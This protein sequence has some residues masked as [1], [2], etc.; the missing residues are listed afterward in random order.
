MPESPPGTVLGGLSFFKVRTME[1][2]LY[3]GKIFSVVKR[4]IPGT[5]PHDV[6]LHAPVVTII[7]FQ[8]NEQE[9]TPDVLLIETVRPIISPNPVLEVPAGFIE[10]GESVIEAAR[11]ELE[12]ETG[13]RAGELQHVF[14]FY[15]SPG[16]TDE[17]VNIVWAWD[18]QKTQMKLD[19]GEIIT[20]V[21]PV[22]LRKAL[23]LM[24][25]GKINGAGPVIG[26][27][28]TALFGGY[29]SYRNW[30]KGSVLTPP[31]APKRH[32]K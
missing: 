12:E 28:Y 11:R 14:S 31:I 13:Y 20:R 3:K 7:A 17:Q 15:S 18:L 26:L 6:V 1:K 5:F 24:G 10:E 22:Q 21:I 30:D 2:E 25:S 29:V 19:E 4:D 9:E 23:E 8:E 27:T 32:L 16:F